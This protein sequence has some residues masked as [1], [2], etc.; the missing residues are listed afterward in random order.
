MDPNVL[1]P[2]F[3]KSKSPADLKTKGSCLKNHLKNLC[4]KLVLHISQAIIKK[5]PAINLLRYSIENASTKDFGEL[6]IF[7]L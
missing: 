5:I 3:I 1:K 4:V 6:A 2:N 7:F